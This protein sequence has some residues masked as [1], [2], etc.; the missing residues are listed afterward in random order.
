MKID[1][2]NA[3]STRL[4]KGDGGCGGGDGM[5]DGCG[6]RGD[7]GVRGLSPSLSAAKRPRGGIIL[8]VIG[9]IFFIFIFWFFVRLRF[10]TAEEGHNDTNQSIR[11]YEI[12]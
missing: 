9:M 4:V 12:V 3:I 6:G 10:I 8:I 5:G 1:N 2:M 11:Q 7:S